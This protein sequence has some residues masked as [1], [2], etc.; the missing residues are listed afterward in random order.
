MSRILG[1]AWDAAAPDPFGADDPVEVARLV[2]RALAA[3][4]RKA[5]DVVGV[6]VVTE[7]EPDAASLARFARRAL[8]PHGASVTPVVRLAAGAD[9][10]A[11]CAAAAGIAV[12][13][14]AGRPEPAGPSVVIAIALG[15][16]LAATALCL[17]DSSRPGVA[18]G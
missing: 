1:R 11:R 18:A 5:F 2:R 4:G 16:G 15:P 3:A 14:V 17:G 13:S 8:G 6:V 7:Q 10:A 12:G 9:H